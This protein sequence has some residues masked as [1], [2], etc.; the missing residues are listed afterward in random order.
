MT[1]SYYQAK[2]YFPSEKKLREDGF[3]SPWSPP[4]LA[5]PAAQFKSHEELNS[6]YS[7]SDLYSG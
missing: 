4:G 6:F 2:R 5:T 7:A 3:G 1:P